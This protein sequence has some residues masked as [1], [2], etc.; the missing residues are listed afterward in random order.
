[1]HGTRTARSSSPVRWPLVPSGSCC[2][3]SPWLARAPACGASWN[4]RRALHEPFHLLLIANS[5]SFLRSAFAEQTL[6]LAG[7]A[8]V[9]VDGAVEGTS[10]RGLLLLEQML[11]V[12][13]QA[14]EFAG[15]CLAEP[16]RG[17]LACLHLG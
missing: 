14:A 13:L 8:G 4:Q 9:H 6:D 12:L 3:S 2:R 16:L 17:R 10:A 11:T 5:W 7:I 1:G 15:T